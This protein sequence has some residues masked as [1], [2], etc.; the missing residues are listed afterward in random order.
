[1]EFV[2]ET[3][4]F[5][6]KSSWRGKTA[7]FKSKIKPKIFNSYDRKDLLPFQLKSVIIIELEKIMSRK[8][9]SYVST[10]GHLAMVKEIQ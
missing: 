7:V 10:S 3:L 8:K 9:T 2:K 6:V 5:K 4:C 1:M